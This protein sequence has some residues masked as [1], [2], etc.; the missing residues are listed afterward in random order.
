MLLLT[1]TTRESQDFLFLND[2]NDDAFHD[3]LE[4]DRREAESEP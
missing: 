1:G 3:S 2:S 4:L